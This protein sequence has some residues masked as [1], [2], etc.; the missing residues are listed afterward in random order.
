MIEFERPPLPSDN[1][2]MVPNHLAT[3]PALNGNAVRLVLYI[4]SRPPGWKTVRARI[5]EAIGLGGTAFDAAVKRAEAGGWLE[6]RQDRANGGEL[7]HTRYRVAFPPEVYRN[8]VTGKPGDRESE[9]GEA[10]E[11]VVPRD[12]ETR[13]LGHYETWSLNKT[14]SKTEP[15][16]NVGDAAVAVP[17]EVVDV[18]SAAVE[19]VREDVDRLLD[20]LD[21]QIVEN[22]LKP[23]NRTKGNRNAMRLLLDRDGYTEDQVDYMIRWAQRSPFWHPNIRSATKLREKFDTLVGQMRQEFRRP[24]PPS[25]TDRQSGWDASVVNLNEMGVL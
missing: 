22:G 25:T 24:A 15:S 2:T 4:V 20:L 10:L 19:E 6:R 11:N 5:M 3:D 9:Y 12:H 13:G 1:F 21:S 16:K 23:P 17:D 7:A 14:E 18:D 8:T